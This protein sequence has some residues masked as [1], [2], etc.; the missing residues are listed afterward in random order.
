MYPNYN[1][2]ILHLQGGA[3][4]AH[5]AGHCNAPNRRQSV[6]LQQHARNLLDHYKPLMSVM[7]PGKFGLF[8]V[9]VYR[10]KHMRDA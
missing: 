4:R 8:P 5:R 2:V 1:C 6:A 7:R 10:D 9:L 3:A